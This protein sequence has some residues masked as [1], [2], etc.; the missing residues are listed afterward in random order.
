MGGS[1]SIEVPL[2]LDAKSQEMNHL[3]GRALRT[4]K[5]GEQIGHIPVDQDPQADFSVIGSG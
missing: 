5:T 3:P 2:K 1:V 4:A